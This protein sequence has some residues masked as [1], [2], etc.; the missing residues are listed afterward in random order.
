MVRIF[1]ITENDRVV[2]CTYTPEDSSLEGYVEVD[3]ATQEI[4]SVK[5]SD[6]EY[7]K[8]MYVSHVR[9]KIAELINNK[10]DFPSEI[11]AIWY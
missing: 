11:T 4:K 3:K 9:E 2:S 7:G 1:N 10:K 8:K 6:Y 5:Y